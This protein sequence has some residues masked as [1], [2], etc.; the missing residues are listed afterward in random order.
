[1]PRNRTAQQLQ[2]AAALEQAILANQN[3]F[4]RA[5][6]NTI[7]QDDILYDLNGIRVVYTTTGGG[8]GGA[9]GWYDNRYYSSLN[10]IDPFEDKAVDFMEGLVKDDKICKTKR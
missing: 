9:G 6:N 2:E 1:M 3:A 8:G 5:T 4:G 10:F 7:P